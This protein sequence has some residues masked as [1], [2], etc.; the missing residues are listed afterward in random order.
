MAT[1]GYIA[2]MLGVCISA[3]ATAASIAGITT[4]NPQ[5]NISGRRGVYMAALVAIA[6]TLALLVA[7]VTNDFSI[8]YVFENSNLAMGRG[9]TFVALYAANEGS[10]LFLT[11]A[12]SVMASI[13]LY[14]APKRFADALPYTVAILGAVLCFFFTVMVT[15]ANPFETLDL[16]PADGRGINP[17]LLHPG[18]YSH[19]P[20]IMSGLIGIV[21]PFAFSS[22]ALISGQYGDDWVDIA[23][24]FAIVMWALLGVGMLLGAWWAYTILGW[25]GYWSW[26]PIENVALMPWLALTAFIHSIMVQRRRGM[27]RMWNIALID[28]AVLLALLGVFINRGGPVVS[29]HSFAASTLG[30]VF[31]SFMIANFVFAFAVFVWRLPQLQS[32]RG[33]ETFMSREASFLVNNFLLL[34]V[35][36]I[37]LWGVIYPVFSGLARDVEVTVAA[38]YFNRVNG[39]VLLALVI[40]MGIGPLLPWRRTNPDSLRKW[41]IA[42]S[43]CALA[44]AGAL[45]AF[46]INELW[47]IAGFAA[48]AFAATAVVEEWVLGTRARIR[49]LNEF[50]TLAWWR[51]IKGNRARH[52]G[53]IVHLAIL[54]F[55]IGVIGT[56]FF[57]VR[58]DAAVAEGQSLVIDDYRIAF[59]DTQT[60]DRSDRLAQWALIDVYRIDPDSYA[61]EFQQ[62]RVDERSGFVTSSDVRPGDR[63]VGEIIPQ[64]EFYRTVNQVSVRAGILGNPL[65][66]L[67]VI[68]RDFLSDGRLS[69]AVSINPLAVW[70]W[71]AGPI[72]ILGTAIALWPNPELERATASRKKSNRT[73]AHPQIATR[74]EFT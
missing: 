66:D 31:L 14:L 51:L 16:V 73:T 46:G 5:L 56:Q 58:F 23:R 29:V 6:A 42:P 67:Y 53:Y 48:I 65:E 47:A 32:E 2:L 40:L 72:F 49:N 13:S 35:T 52:G 19:P 7:F 43:L 36:A 68:P 57:D 27:F 12:L 37:T 39:P 62:A 59:R 3:Y 18:F 54:V 60:D 26:D 70:L 1:F 22:G 64:H 71:I 45:V 4:R 9:Y 17:L 44:V 50:P 34:L 63:K 41:L 30:F 25:G 15:L 33:I 24:V 21:I 61:A 28:I 10:L 11:L 74:R 69:L 55:A 20:M 8:R 38:P